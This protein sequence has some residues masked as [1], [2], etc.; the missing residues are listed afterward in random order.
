MEE[1]Y[2]SFQ[3]P[4]GF[5]YKVLDKEKYNKKLNAW[6]S[7]I[8]TLLF[9]FFCLGALTNFQ[10]N[11]LS[12]YVDFV[13]RTVL[14]YFTMMF[15]I[16]FVYVFCSKYTVDS[17][18]DPFTFLCDVTKQSYSITICGFKERFFPKT[19]QWMLTTKIATYKL[20]G[21]VSGIKI[22][23]AHG[24][25]GGG[26]NLFMMHLKDNNNQIATHTHHNNC[27]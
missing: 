13:A 2:H 11:T 1:Q 3:V 12:F 14:I 10:Y 26:G 20:S 22:R 4:F 15:V 19:Y 6:F 21:I 18:F 23:H 25:G 17:L 16:V 8:F 5:C 27:N 24:S 7:F 9:I